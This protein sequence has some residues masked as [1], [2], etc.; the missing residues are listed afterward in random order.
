MSGCVALMYHVI[1][2]PGV[3]KERQWCCSAA[4]FRDQM[5]LLRDSGYNVV[6]MS[7]LVGWMERRAELP[8]DAV[9]ITIDDGTRCIVDAALPVLSAMAFPAIAYVVSGRLGADN[10]WLQRS[11]WSP[12]KLVDAADLRALA[13]EGIEIGSHSVSHADLSVATPARIESE[14][15]DSK[16]RLEDVL[17]REVAHFA[18][19]LGRLSRRARDA[20]EAAGYR[21]ACTVE[22]G[23]IR[24]S[25]DRFR[26]SRVEVYNRDDLDTFARKVRR[27]SADP[28]LGL[29][30]TRRIA[31]R[32]LQRVGLYDRYAKPGG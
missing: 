14:L 30:A 23:R 19:P 26:L 8:P 17:G 9:C 11:G 5:Q 4:A 32:A 3:E 21:S 10:D 28:G 13:T 22:D 2:E 25:D 12:R 29:V 31:R 6:S 16:R 1:G 7:Q 18:Y 20:A 27:A 24:R 15:R